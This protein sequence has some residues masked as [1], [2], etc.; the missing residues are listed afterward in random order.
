MI[1]AGVVMIVVILGFYVLS[2]PARSPGSSGSMAPDFQLQEVTV[3]GLTDNM[4][5][6]SSF[7][8]KVI[9]LE[10]MMSWCHYCQEMA[11]SV[12][13]LNDKYSGQDV[14]FLSVAGT[15]SG[16]TAQ[17]TA[18][19]MTERGATWTHVLDKDNSV[20]RTY[21]VQGTPSYFIIDKSGRILSTF[22]GLVATETFSAAIDAALSG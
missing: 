18:E 5:R 21:R 14:V 15:E 13:Y 1:F 16:A 9:V 8:G 3:Q 22:Q 20:F 11:P 7:R 6:L 12:A 4:I 2:Q 19:F 10:F 17:S